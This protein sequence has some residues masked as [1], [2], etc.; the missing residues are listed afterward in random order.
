MSI[1]ID[2]SLVGFYPQ[3]FIDALISRKGGEVHG[4]FIS[5]F[6]DDFDGEEVIENT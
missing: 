5:D 4:R 2:A 1:I 6:H 3:H